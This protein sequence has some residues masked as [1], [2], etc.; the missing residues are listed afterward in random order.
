LVEQI[1]VGGERR[2]RGVEDEVDERQ[3]EENKQGTTEEL[4]GEGTIKAMIY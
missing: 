1:G 3:G 2:W 4:S